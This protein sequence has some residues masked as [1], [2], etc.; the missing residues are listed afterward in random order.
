MIKWV[1]NKKIDHERV[2][3]LLQDSIV[4]NHYTNGSPAVELLEKRTRT[5]LKIDDSKAVVCVSNGTV[6]LW[7]A[8]AALELYYSKDFQFCTQS[9]TFP[10]SAQGYL[11][12]VKIIDIDNDGGIDLDLI[13]ISSCDGIIVTNIFG[14]IVDIAKYETWCAKHSKILIFDNA[15]TANT[16]YKGKNSCNYGNVATLSFHHTKP[17]GFGEGGCIIMDKKYERALRN[18]MNFGID[19]TSPMGKWDRKGGNY[20]M[21]DLQAVYILQYLDN[22]DSIIDKTVNLYSYFLDK[23]AA[24]PMIKVFPNF[25][26]GIPFVSCICIFVDD[27]NNV[28]QKL[29]M[30]NIYCR[31]YYNPLMPTPVAQSIYN[32]ILCIPCN[33]DMTRTDI[34]KIV[35]LLI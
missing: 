5:L 7:A 9:F 31:K 3:D 27:S 16:F 12:D 1:P 28:M 4:T 30:N 35:N 25:S 2:R 24:Y 19:N 26:D 6:A 34:D 15:A 17:I 32:N 21:S 23:I 10:A 18:I 11:S 20:K 29:L 8:V 14:N 33:I 13:D 22:F